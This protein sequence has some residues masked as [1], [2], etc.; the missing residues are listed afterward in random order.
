MFSSCDTLRNSVV[1]FEGSTARL[2]M[3]AQRRY[4]ESGEP[5][6]L[7]RKCDLRDGSDLLLFVVRLH[8]IVSANWKI[9]VTY[10][11]FRYT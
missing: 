11:R 3:Y 5:E 8:N 6:M 9:E 10:S 2:C 4:F 7:E 1:N